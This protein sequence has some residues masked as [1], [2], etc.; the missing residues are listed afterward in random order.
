MPRRR[1]RPP[2]ADS[3]TSSSFAGCDCA[4]P[5]GYF[6]DA[7]AG[8]A[9]G[10]AVFESHGTADA[11]E[12]AA[13]TASPRPTSSSIGS[14]VVKGSTCAT[15][16]SQPRSPSRCREAYDITI[17]ERDDR[18]SVS[19]HIKLASDVAIGQAHEVAERV[20]GTL[21]VG[22][23]SKGTIAAMPTAAGVF[24]DTATVAMTGADTHP[25]ND[26]FT[27]SVQPKWF[28]SLRP[29][30]SRAGGVPRGR[31]TVESCSRAPAA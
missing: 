30:R 3:V 10:Q 29:N 8:V 9:P 22:Q 5:A 2:S 6:V 1:P 25:A 13:Q 16:C 28:V 7:V 15:A 26:A 17:Y 23:Q 14:R 11:V 18:V 19:P 20:E 31:W 12:A 4:S 24:A 21:G 27:P